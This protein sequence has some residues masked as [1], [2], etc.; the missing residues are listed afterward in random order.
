MSG[1]SLHGDNAR[2]SPFGVCRACGVGLV[3]VNYC[4]SCGAPQRRE[5]P[6][7]PLGGR[8]GGKQG[9]RNGKMRRKRSDAG[10]KHSSSSNKVEG[11]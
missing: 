6:R 9:T 8:V 1:S 7:K 10:K 3:Q 11:H 5:A 2:A 4:S